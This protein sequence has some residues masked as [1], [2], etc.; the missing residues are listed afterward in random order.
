MLFKQDLFII[1]NIN[2]NYLKSFRL[3]VSIVYFR[4]KKEIEGKHKTKEIKTGSGK[5]KLKLVVTAKYLNRF[6]PICFR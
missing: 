2:G 5:Q 1:S 3:N 4:K 6:L